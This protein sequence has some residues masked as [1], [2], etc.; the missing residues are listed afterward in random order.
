MDIKFSFKF[1]LRCRV[2]KRLRK[3][4]RAWWRHLHYLLVTLAV[5]ARL[6]HFF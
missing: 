2:S 1:R 6:L 3:R 4:L 5:M